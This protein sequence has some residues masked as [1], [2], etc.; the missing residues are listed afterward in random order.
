MTD[1]KKIAKSANDILGGVSTGVIGAIGG[2]PAAQGLS[3]AVG[4]VD[5]IITEYVPGEEEVPAEP[6]RTRARRFD[7]M[8]LLGIGKVATAEAPAR[9]QVAQSGAKP[10]A[11]KAAAPPETAPK[12]PADAFSEYVAALKQDPAVLLAQ[13]SSIRKE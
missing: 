1:W 11:E 12:S 7:G 8:D 10:I 2:A 13:F 9:P 5:G 6:E 4:A 3:K